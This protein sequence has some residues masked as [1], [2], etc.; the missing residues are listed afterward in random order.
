MSFLL[1]GPV[2]LIFLSFLRF[3][4]NIFRN[5]G[6][7][8]WLSLFTFKSAGWSSAD[9]GEFLRA[10]LGIRPVGGVSRGFGLGLGGFTVACLSWP[11]AVLQSALTALIALVS[12]DSCRVSLLGS[13]SVHYHGAI[14]PL[15]FKANVN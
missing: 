8:G 13:I 6:S 2:G 9:P 3:D 14:P 4:L 12:L 15:E 7:A 10:G 1:I 11:L 5:S